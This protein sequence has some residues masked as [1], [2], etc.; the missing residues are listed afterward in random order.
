MSVDT[1]VT[2]LVTSHCVE[3]HGVF[4]Q[5]HFLLMMMSTRWTTN[6]EKTEHVGRNNGH[7]TSKNRGIYKELSW[8]SF[9]SF[10]WM[11]VSSIFRTYNVSLIDISFFFKSLSRSSLDRRFYHWNKAKWSIFSLFNLVISFSVLSHLWIVYSLLSNILKRIDFSSFFFSIQIHF[12]FL[13]KHMCMYMP[14]LSSP[15]VCDLT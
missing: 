1:I 11:R 8:R 13:S 14:S 12:L 4:S 2:R 7:T 5:T 10:Y 3:W 9:R 15:F 6:D